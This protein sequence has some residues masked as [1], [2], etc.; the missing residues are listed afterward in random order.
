MSEGRARGGRNKR[1]SHIL[2]SRDY[3]RMMTA[4]TNRASL[5]RRPFTTDDALLMLI[6]FT[7]RLL[8]F[9]RWYLSDTRG[10][11]EYRL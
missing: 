11:I 2:L 9:V 7:S 3:S 6:L 4:T 5:P 10:I 1:D 8:S